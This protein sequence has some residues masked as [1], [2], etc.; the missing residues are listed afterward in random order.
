MTRASLSKPSIAI[1]L[2]GVALTLALLLSS[3]PLKR[4]KEEKEEEVEKKEKKEKRSAEEWKRA[5]LKKEEK[6][7]TIVF[8]AVICFVNI[9]LN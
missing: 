5:C 9:A 3:S 2:R 4:E 7:L 6:D 8:I 1:G